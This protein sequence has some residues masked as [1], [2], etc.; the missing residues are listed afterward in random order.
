MKRVGES[1]TLL[2]FCPAKARYRIVFMCDSLGST[3]ATKL[4][5]Q[6]GTIATRTFV[7][8]FVIYSR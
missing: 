8:T 4:V 6:I 5:V 2:P 3:I 7:L 1:R